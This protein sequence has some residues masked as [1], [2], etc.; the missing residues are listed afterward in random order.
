MKAAL[1]DVQDLWNQQVPSVVFGVTDE[2][3][4]ASAKIK[5]LR[6]TQDTNVTFEKAYLAK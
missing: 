3:I 6:F 4:A 5:G 2:A 1:K